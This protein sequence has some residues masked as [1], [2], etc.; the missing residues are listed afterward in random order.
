VACALLATGL[1]R[2]IPTSRLEPPSENPVY[3]GP[4]SGGVA[5]GPVTREDVGLLLRGVPFAVSSG[6]DF[7][8]R[9]KEAGTALVVWRH[10]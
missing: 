1:T 7:G 8:L 9:I 6:G 2:L 3:P 10:R 4:S 5:A